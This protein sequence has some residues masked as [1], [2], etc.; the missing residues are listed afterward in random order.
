MIPLANLYSSFYIPAEPF[1]TSG[2][3]RGSKGWFTPRQANIAVTRLIRDDLTK[4]GQKKGLTLHDAKIA[5][6]DT[7]LWTHIII[8]FVR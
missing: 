7:K 1:K 5:V 2:L 4:S 3:L 6:L 8:T